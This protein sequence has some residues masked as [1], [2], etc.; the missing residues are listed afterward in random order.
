MLQYVTDLGSFWGPPGPAEVVSI[1]FQDLLH[2]WERI[3]TCKVKIWLGPWVLGRSVSLSPCQNCLEKCCWQ[4]G[5]PLTS[6]PGHGQFE[7]TS[8][9]NISIL[10]REIC[11][12]MESFSILPLHSCTSK[13]VG[14]NSLSNHS[15]CHLSLL[16]LGVWLLLCGFMFHVSC[17]WETGLLPPTLMCENRITPCMFPEEFL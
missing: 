14:I 6:C 2:P 3:V 15:F 1:P 7:E 17:F 11:F 12:Y 10:R 16:P 5:Q 9:A 13:V 8:K 4:M